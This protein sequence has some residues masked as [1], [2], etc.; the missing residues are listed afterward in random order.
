M[1]RIDPLF[2]QRNSFSFVVS[3]FL[4]A[5]MIIGYGPV[6][7][8]KNQVIV[9]IDPGHGGSDPG[10]LP[11]NKQLMS[12]KAINLLIAQK[13]GQYIEQNL[14]N[15]KIIYTRTDDSYPSLTDRVNKANAAR[16]DYFISIHCNANHNKHV[17]GTESH[18]HSLKSDKGVAL[19]RAFEEGFVT[20]AG[21]FSRGVKD[22][23]DREH[24]LQ[25]L[26]YTAMN[27]VLIECGFLTHDQEAQ[28]LNTSNGQDILASSI[29]N[30]F[31]EYIVKAH[32][33]IAFNKTIP[34]GT[35]ARKSD[36]PTN[37]SGAFA[38]QLMSSKE[39]IDT[40]IQEFKRIGL[41]VERKK[42]NSTSAYKYQ[43]RT[44]IYASQDDAKRDLE[45]VQK[46][47]FKDAYIIQV[48][49]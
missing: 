11:A 10:H 43:Y 26:K 49:K 41:P 38:I 20:K 25:V 28:F 13:L 6:N 42:V 44:S 40:S 5:C 33:T 12:E 3:F 18:V 9:V 32:P 36:G 48:N 17:H 15:V 45:K 23:E 35:I 2:S 22:S 16:A 1:K 19:A 24:T 39:P 21:R 27:S 31:K 4:F 8:Q 14:Q 46:S 37:I 34:T 29:F 7:A 30:A 47:G